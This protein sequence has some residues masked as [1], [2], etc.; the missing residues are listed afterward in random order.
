MK[1]LISVDLE[2]ISG[3]VHSAETNPDRYG[4]ERGAGAA[5]RP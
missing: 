5:A 3:I 4:C 1:V 2:G